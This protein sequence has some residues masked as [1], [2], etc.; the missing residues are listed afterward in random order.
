MSMRIIVFGA[1]GK[2]GRLIVGELLNRGHQV[3]A[4]VHSKSPFN[5]DTNLQI[6]KG[7][8]YLPKQVAEAMIGQ[9]MVISALGSW[10][11]PGKDVLTVGMTSIIPAMKTVGIR[12]IVSLTGH[13]A[14]AP[15]DA[16]SNFDRLTH[17]AMELVAPKVL[18]D[19][20]NHIRVLQGSGLD[21]TV[22]RSPLM[23][24][25]PTADYALQAKRPLPWTTISRLA[26]VR[27]MADQSADN[28]FYG[29]APFVTAA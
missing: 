20:E 28:R 26:V 5:A 6:V 11:T 12:R 25:K 3:T 21:W 13:Y 1:G 10:H 27:A 8:I 22:L 2:V 7:D 4:F 9:E 29:Q 15:G 16:T 19:G 24:K 17:A 14:F 23:T 18:H